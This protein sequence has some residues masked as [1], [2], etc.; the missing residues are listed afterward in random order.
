[1]TNTDVP[2]CSDCGRK[3]VAVWEVD[4]TGH[5][6]GLCCIGA[7]LVQATSDLRLMEAE[8]IIERL[9]LSPKRPTEDDD[10]TYV[11]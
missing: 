3:Q 6:L 7:A 11:L 9:G 10:T 1:M 5:A 8:R 4:G 2:Q